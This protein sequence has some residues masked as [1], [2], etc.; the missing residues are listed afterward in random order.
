M[1]IRIMMQAFLILISQ[2]KFHSF[3]ITVVAAYIWPR[4]VTVNTF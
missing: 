4:N 1:Y 2:F 3:I